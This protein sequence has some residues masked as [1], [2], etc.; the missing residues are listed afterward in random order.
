M[1]WLANF[2]FFLR[3]F[4]CRL[5]DRFVFR[6]IFI[7][8]VFL[9]LLFSVP[10]KFSIC[11]TKY[12]HFMF[13]CIFRLSC[14]SFFFCFRSFT[15]FIRHF[16]VYLFV[17]GY[18]N[19]FYVICLFIFLVV[20]SQTIFFMLLVRELLHFMCFPVVYLMFH[21]KQRAPRKMFKKNLCY[22]L[23]RN[24]FRFCRSI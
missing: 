22:L 10:F 3:V 1:C 13:L 19:S 17:A 20:C 14:Y 12:K 16:L 4:F 6:W 8:F 21:L 9:L 7:I 11:I 18:T 24:N 2:Y 23:N 15:R 5:F